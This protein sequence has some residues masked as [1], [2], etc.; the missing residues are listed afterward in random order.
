MIIWPII[1]SSESRDAGAGALARMLLSAA[2][3]GTVAASAST[4]A[5]M[6]ARAESGRR[7]ILISLVAM[8]WP[9]DYGSI[10]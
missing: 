3:T 10:R 9:A 2:E 1:R 4:R 5:A 7:M 8:D 6:A